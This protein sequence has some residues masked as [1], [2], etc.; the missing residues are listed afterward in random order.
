MKRVSICALRR[1]KLEK[2]LEKSGDKILLVLHQ[3]LRAAFEWG[4]TPQMPAFIWPPKRERGLC[5]RFGDE[6]FV[7][8][9]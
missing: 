2:D 8:M 4:S 1:G 3:I 7:T 5:C 6:W 9:S